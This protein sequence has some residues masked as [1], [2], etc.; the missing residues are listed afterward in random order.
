MNE[1]ITP[2]FDENE[3]TTEDIAI[4][5]AFDAI[6]DWHI[7]PKD[8][9]SI[10]A[11]DSV[12]P[13]L[14]EDTEMLIVF[15]EEVGEDIAKMQQ[16]LSQIAQ[17]TQITPARFTIFQRIGHKLR[18]T[19]GAIGYTL[20]ATIA[21]QI[22]LLAEQ[23]LH[24]NIEPGIGY[25]T[26][27][28]A[29]AI[30]DL[31]RNQLL[32]TGQE[33]DNPHVLTDLEEVYQQ[34]GINIHQLSAPITA[35]LTGPIEDGDR[36]TTIP[37]DLATTYPHALNPASEIVTN[38]TTEAEGTVF[39][40][41]IRVEANRYQK[42]LHHTEQLLELQAKLE[43]AQRDVKTTQQAQKKALAHLQQL[44]PSLSQLSVAEHL[45]QSQEDPSSS[46]LIM[47][48]LN[49]ANQETLR[50]PRRSSRPRPRLSHIDGKWDELDLEHYTE[51]D[52]L[53]RA[54]RE[55]ITQLAI[56]NTQANAALVTQNSVQQDY[57]D[58][59]TIVRNDT[60][61]LRLTPLQTLVP[62]LQQIITT[63]ALA[64]QYQVDFRV[65][66]E[67]LE[68]D[69]EILEALTPSLL[70]MLH[71]CISDTSVIQE[72]QAE[73]YH[74]WFRAQSNGNDIAIEI[75]FSMPVLGGTLELLQEPVQKINGSINLQRNTSGGVSFHLNIPR[76][77]G[78]IQC[79]LLQVGDQQMVVPIA[80]IQRVSTLEQEQL[81]H[82]YDLKDMLRLSSN[83]TSNSYASKLKTVLVIQMGTS[84]KTVGI[85]VDEVITELELIIKPLATFLQRPGIKE[86][87]L[88][89]QGN[90]LLALDMIELIKSYRR[91]SPV[92]KDER[93]TN[94]NG[95][96]EAH[97]PK[98]LVADDSAFLRQAVIQTLKRDNYEVA[99][100]KD[101]MEAIEQLLENTPDI[102]L[103]DIEMPNLNG[104]DVLNM[105][106]EYPE[107]A[108]VKIIMLTSRTS[109]K[110]IQ[111]ARDL[112][113][114]AY[115]IKPCPQETLLKT[116]QEQFA[117]TL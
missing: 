44:E 58:L 113:A 111:R 86:S 14:D 4:L 25:Q 79:L 87:A 43:L 114:Q 99:E 37:L 68:I 16:G 101:G 3:L 72:E 84:R 20:M 24:G 105:I 52:L 39:R 67:Q 8:A 54:V 22:E 61:M 33:S 109:D 19:A 32:E 78:S 46:S 60:Q 11:V 49:E 112:G 97:V 108:H 100:A 23:I 10:S 64:Q 95:Q 6:E 103:L 45:T 81:D 77:Q 53:T 89:G 96:P 83:A 85:L 41:F 36:K 75:G 74:V 73:T 34:W 70:Q 18:G 40:P 29:T 117:Q 56:C 91:S 69:Q 38:K 30:L 71:N 12:S 5:N 55:A 62:Q 9:S 76:A 57:I 66:G 15:L 17:S 116:I 92:E 42:L 94:R 48:I 115:L 107:L 106:H 88:D 13:E 35:P 47:R 21:E 2:P 93:D 26:I 50:M 98:I 102:F 110:H 7:Y 28:R 65:S 31:C 63:S 90:I 59:V 1:E 51:K 104:Y 27:N 80:H 82:C